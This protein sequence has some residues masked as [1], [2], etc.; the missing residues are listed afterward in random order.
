M[1]PWMASWPLWKNVPSPMFWKMW[2]VSTNG[3][4]PIH[5]VPSWPMQV[6]PMM[7][8]KSSE[9][10]SRV[11]VWQPM[12]APTAAPSGTLVERLWGHPEQK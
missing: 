12:P 10:I 11:M 9:S 8:P 3:A 2:G 5:W 6:S 4:M 7:S 1:A